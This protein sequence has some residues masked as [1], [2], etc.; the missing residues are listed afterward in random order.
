MKQFFFSILLLTLFSA[1]ALADSPELVAS[2]PREVVAGKVFQVEYSINENSNNRPV[3]DF[4]D[5]FILLAGPGYSY[6]ESSHFANG[7]STSSV[8][9]TYTYTLR[10]D[11][12]GKYTIP[13]ATISSSNGEIK[14][15]TLTIEVL[16]P[17]KNVPTAGS[18]RKAGR[19][20]TQ[21]ISS[22]DIFVMP[23]LSKTKV[24]E[25][26][27]VLLTYKLYVYKL[28]VSSIG[29]TVPEFNDF[30]AQEIDLTNNRQD[31][32][33][34]YNG[35]NYQTLPLRQFVLFPQKSG[36]LV[37]PSVNIEAT[38][39]MVVA[40]PNASLDPF[41]AFFGG[42][43]QVV[44]VKKML[45]VPERKITVEPLPKGQPMGFS[46]G[47]GNFTLKS[48][49]STTKL[50]ANEAV[51]VKLT[52]SGNGNL[53]TINVPDVKF[54]EDF[55]VYDPKV[56]DNY[57]IRTNGYHGSKVIEYLAIPR[58]AGTY[59]IPAVT[60]SYFDTKSN[61]YKTLVTEKY[62][63][64]VEKGDVTSS[65]GAPLVYTN[66]EEVKQLGNDIRHIKLGSSEQCKRSDILFATKKQAWIYLISLI[67]FLAYILL[68]QKTLAKNSDLMLM[69]TKKAN[70]FAVKRLRVAQQMLKAGETSKFYDETLKALWGYVS[71]KLAMPVSELTKD[72]IEANLLR[73]GVDE[74]LISSFKNLLDECEFARYAPGRS[75]Y[76][77][78]SIYNQAVEII[79]KMENSIH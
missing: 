56:E 25:Q 27:A 68:K 52:L 29:N 36:E 55:E 44:D 13:A 58:S 43:S 76:T 45:K 11:R 14:S 61:S 38:V 57:T 41:T 53:K 28:Q 73:K 78:D 54:P 2:A 18:D 69:R 26:E 33:E 66:K 59:E 74:N 15:N 60:L 46:G 19:S 4:G 12:P 10:A 51:T 34:H 1:P 75:A 16:P 8:N 24:F 63:L 70:K 6:S 40:N 65:S 5:D 32:L 49:I 7:K 21:N 71:D 79:N 3:V 35:R 67:V 64:N 48:E 77:K 22:E 23:Q 20:G 50:K 42:G 17:D 47:V 72:N 30:Q 39:Q 37:I 62:I 9:I 31:G